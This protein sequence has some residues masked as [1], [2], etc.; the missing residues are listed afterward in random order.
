MSRK[1]NAT[2]RVGGGTV[3]V[4]LQ[5][6]IIATIELKDNPNKNIWTRNGFYGVYAPTDDNENFSTRLY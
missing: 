2:Y 4:E 6:R 3:W 5:R 1:E